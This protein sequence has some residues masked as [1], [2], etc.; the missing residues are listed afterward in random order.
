M[1]DNFARFGKTF[2]ENLT[3]LIIDDRAFS[4]QILE[5][6]DI[7]FF[8]QKYLQVFNKLLKEYK[9]K[10]NVHPTRSILETVL[11]TSMTEENELVQK[12]VRDF[13]AR[14]TTATDDV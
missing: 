6:L 9:D 3:R 5:V 2:Q 10:Y 11:R 4:D 8:E 14:S 1:T 12:Q 7:N 13:F